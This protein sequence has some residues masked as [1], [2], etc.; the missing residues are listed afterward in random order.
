MVHQREGEGK[1]SSPHLVKALWDQNPP[2]I[3]RCDPDWIIILFFIHLDAFREEK[4]EE[5]SHGTI[6]TGGTQ[7]GKIG[8]ETF[9]ER[10]QESNHVFW[11]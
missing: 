9:W 2:K 1:F 3:G 4:V 7:F 11:G 6:F 10:F 8:S 5:S